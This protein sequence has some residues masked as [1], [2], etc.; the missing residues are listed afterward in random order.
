MTKCIITA[1]LAYAVALPAL[2]DATL[3]QRAI[4]IIRAQTREPEATKFERVEYRISKDYKGD[5]LEVVC[6]LVNAK[7]AFG[8]YTGYVPFAFFA[9]D[10]II[11][12]SWNEPPTG[13]AEKILTRDCPDYLK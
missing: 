6:G 5:P 1:L 3:A 7:N 4:D 11:M 10:T 13:I 8:G 9:D 2:A 12:G